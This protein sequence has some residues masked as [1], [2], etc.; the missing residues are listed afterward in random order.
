MAE[1]IG[2][3]VFIRPSYIVSL[4]EYFGGREYS[5]L[6]FKLNQENLKERSHNG[7]ISRKACS[8][9]KNAIN[10][11]LCA[12][13]PK[14]VYHKKHDRWFNFKVAFITL[15]LPDTTERVTDKDFQK[16]LL[17]PWL[18]YMRKYH[19]LRNYVWK[20]EFQKNGKL[21]CHITMD[22]FVHWAKIRST[23]NSL[24]GKNGYLA[25]FYLK[26]GHSDP[27][28]TDVHS[29]RSI[30]NLGAYLAKYMSK[31]SEDLKKMKGRIWGCSYELSR[32]NNTRVF[33]NRDDCQTELRPLFG[34][35]IEFKPIGAIDKWTNQFKQFGEVFFLKYT[36]WMQ[37]I[38]GEI[39]S[40][41]DD[42]VLQ[43]KNVA[44]N[45]PLVYEV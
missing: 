27:N 41:F 22:A 10:W 35:N 18:A 8:K 19:G 16:K 3:N 21:H 2:Q 1:Y 11:L 23:W 5:S 17:G 45:A 38:R 14:R 13:E 9:L 24:L 7:V 32:A 36:D 34:R 30:K 20:M 28:S 40:A 44:T 26:F 39:R 4:P 33:I 6:D 12:A 42:A 37:H 29:I 15:T 25:D 31:Q 43:I